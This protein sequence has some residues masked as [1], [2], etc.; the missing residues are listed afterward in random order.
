M[1]NYSFK[2]SL[3]PKV[4]EKKEKER[5]RRREFIVQQF[6]VLWLTISRK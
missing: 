2:I 4:N 3:L 5:E 6:V 1:L